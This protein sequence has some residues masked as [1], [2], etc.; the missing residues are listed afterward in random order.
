MTTT[1]T[2][3]KI[4]SKIETEKNIEL[5]KPKKYKVILINDDYTPFEFVVSLLMNIFDHNSQEAYNI[6]MK[7]HTEGSAIAGIYTYD[8][9]LQK[10]TDSIY[11]AQS[12]GFPLKLILEEC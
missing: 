1:I 4:D 12:F 3:K 5:Y 9:A 6:T 11:L 2:E 7:V 10:Q 8:I